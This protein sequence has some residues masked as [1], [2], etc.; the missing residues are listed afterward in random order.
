M[1][2]E[3]KSIEENGYEIVGH[4]VTVCH[5]DSHTAQEE[6]LVSECQFPVSKRR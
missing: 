6:E 5:N 2:K 4:S 1:W 3:L